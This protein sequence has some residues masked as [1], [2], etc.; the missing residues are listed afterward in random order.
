MIRNI[1]PHNRVEK[2]DFFIHTPRRPAVDDT[3]Y[4]EHGNQQLGCN[5][6]ADFTYTAVYDDNRNAR[7]CALI[8][9]QHCRFCFGYLLHPLQKRVAFRIAGTDNSH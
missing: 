1:F 5:R 6:C 3:V 9:F 7:Q 2:P 4:M 8:K